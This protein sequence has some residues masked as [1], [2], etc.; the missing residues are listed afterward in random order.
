MLTADNPDKRRL[1][2]VLVQPFGFETKNLLPLALA[3]LKSN[4]DDAICEVVII[5]CAIE[6]I[7]ADTS[8][9]RAR[10]AATHADVV[11]VSTWSP[12]YR[13]ALRVL[14]VAKDLLPSVTT[15]IGGNHP[16][17][18][19]TEVMKNPEIDFLFRGESEFT[20]NQFIHQLWSGKLQPDRITGLVY[21]NADGTVVAEN[22]V[23][24][25]E[26][27]DSITP[28]DY[29]FIDLARYIDNGY[30][31]STLSKLNAPIWLT[32]GCPYRCQFCAAPQLN[33]KKIRAHS[34]EY[35][36]EM[37]TS[38]YE[39]GVRYF[40]IIDD[41]FT[42][43]AHYAKDVCRTIIKANFDDVTMATPNGIR[44][45]RGDRELWLLMKRAGWKRLVVAPESGSAHVLDL[46][47]KD[48]DLA[49]VPSI[50]KDMQQAGLLVIAFFIIGYPGE[51]REDMLK[52]RKFILNVGFDFFNFH[53]YQP[54]PGT[55][56][57]DK[58]VSS[59]DISADFTPGGMLSSS[60][61][62]FSKELAGINVR[63]FLA[64][65]YLLS[66]LR[67]PLAAV[68]FARKVGW[69]LP[70]TRLKELIMADKPL[71]EVQK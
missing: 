22:G 18:Y 19:H 59:G 57:F 15:V 8:E 26:D 63:R 58:M 42:F 6:N 13:E 11:A 20:F 10:L 31:F 16:T 61:Q 51:R 39:T 33:G 56:S 30:K 54:L 38:L 35:I 9:F 40:N 25:V 23:S 3:Y 5:D 52:T 65:T 41:N 53:I 24:W 60:S 68:I 43:H 66:W 44:L 28:P 48:L 4:L 1:K 17:T 71:S 7:K 64:V 12:T 49:I 69:R 34:P 36:L 45:Q 70:I 62:I 32:R 29:Q 14:S 2:V 55:P 21:R 27:I 47:Q 67:R 37:M 46:M 50:V